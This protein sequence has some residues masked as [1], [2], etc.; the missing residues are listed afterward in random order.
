MTQIVVVIIITDRIHYSIKTSESFN[1]KTS[2]I[3]QLENNEDELKN[4]KVVVP[5]KYL[6]NF[7]RELKIPLINFEVSLNLKW[8]KNCV[9]TSK[10]T[11]NRIA[12]QEDQLLVNAINNPTNTFFDGTDCK[13]YVPVVT[14][15]AE[16]K[17]KLL[18]QSKTRFP[19]FNY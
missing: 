17:D 3:G 12:A 10:A 9:L 13:L 6:S 14:L 5:L 2:I 7:L 1:Y 16:N 8:S 19:D 18:E 15:S 11:R 4:I